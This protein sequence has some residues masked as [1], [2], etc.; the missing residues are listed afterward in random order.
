MLGS[1]LARSS[2]ETRNIATDGIR[3]LAEI[4]GTASGALTSKEAT[5]T[6]L[7]LLAMIVDA[8][9]MSRIV[10]DAQLSEA[11]TETKKP[12]TGP[13]VRQTDCPSLF[14]SRTVCGR[15]RRIRSCGNLLEN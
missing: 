10:L 13:S 15:E 7:P 11:I 5:N 1:E 8:L 6:G 12:L 4:F 3:K 2:E 14:A 9:T